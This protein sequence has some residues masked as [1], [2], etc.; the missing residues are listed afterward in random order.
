MGASHEQGNKKLTMIITTKMNLRSWHLLYELSECIF[1]TI[2]IYIY[3]CMYV[4]V[5]I[6]ISI[7]LLYIFSKTVITHDHS[8]GT[9]YHE[10]RH[11]PGPPPLLKELQPLL[12]QISGTS[13]PIPSCD[14]SVALLPL[15]HP[16][17]DQWHFYPYPIQ[18][19]T[20]LVSGYP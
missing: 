7:R 17:T 9:E 11:P 18:F 20:V 16:A 19:C 12:R 5:Y 4:Y 15:S 1:E 14:R 13:T 2:Y 6:Y 3:V 8:P 10:H